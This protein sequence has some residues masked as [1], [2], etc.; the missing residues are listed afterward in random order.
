[1]KKHDSTS[2]CPACGSRDLSIF[3]EAE[4]VPVHSVLLMA[5]REQAL[6]YPQGTIRL[7]FCE[8]CGFITNTAFDPTLHEYSTRYEETQSFSPTFNQ[9]HRSLAERLITKY[10]LHEKDI[11]EIGCGKGEFLT[12]LCELG[13]NRGIGVDPAYVPERNPGND[14]VRFIQDLY[15]EKY[16]HLRGD[17]IVC[18]MTLEHIQPVYE[19][20]SMVRR[21]IGTKT[22]ATI[23]F[24]IPNVMYILRDVAFWDVYYEHCSYF[25][26]GSLARLF[27]R[28][29][30]EV[31]ALSTE[32]NDQYL[33]IEARPAQGPGNAPLPEEHDMEE[34]R[35]RVQFFA[36]AYP[37][38]IQQW[39]EQFMRLVD[40]GRRIVLW[41]A[42]SKGVAF[43]T[44][45]T[46]S[47]DVMPYAVDINPHKHGT[48]LAGTG[49]EIVAPEFLA[50]YRPDTVIIMNPI[51]EEEIRR[52]LSA[53]GVA[54]QVMTM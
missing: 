14:R 29:G 2:F 11:I 53:L 51:Y 42:G 37:G 47:Y 28:C 41:G 13:N 33:T 48:F 3:Y 9:F 26:K 24:Q 12:L 36:S 10:D 46:I 38:K 5:T 49:Q 4:N 1:M 16:V 30:F 52:D 44:A 27:R 43:L 19:F 50:H 8:A 31:H 20:V 40:E 17:F 21:S 15:S 39:K 34:L 23:F 45:L 54:A 7:G 18:K 32:Y 22:N 35:Q 6:A 25:S